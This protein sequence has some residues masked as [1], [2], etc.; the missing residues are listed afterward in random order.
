M[1]REL[2]EH[3]V[4]TELVHLFQAL[5]AS[6]NE[7]Q[8]GQNR[9][10]G[11]LVGMAGLAADAGRAAGLLAVWSSLAALDATRGVTYVPPH[12]HTHTHTSTSTSPSPP[13]PAARPHP[14][15]PPHAAGPWWTPAS[16]AR[17]WTRPTAA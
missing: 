5:E 15:P 13:A 10:A 1:P 7:W 6:H 9:C 2:E 4:V 12:T 17:R 11:R 8:P 14:A 3:R 16:C